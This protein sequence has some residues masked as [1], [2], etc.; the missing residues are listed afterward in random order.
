MCKIKLTTQVEVPAHRSLSLSYTGP[1]AKAPVIDGGGGTRLFGVEAGATL[2]LTGVVLAG[3]AATGIDGADGSDGEPGEDGAPG[4]N[5]ADGAFGTPAPGQPGTKGAFATSG[6]SG[7]PGKNGGS[8]TGGAVFNAGK[9]VLTD[10]AVSNS[11]ATGGGGGTGG[12]GGNG[13]NGGDGGH[14]GQGGGSAAGAPG[15]SGADGGVGG[16]GGDSGNGGKGG[17]AE[18]GAIFNS[19]RLVVNGCTFSGDIATGGSGGNAP[20]G[21]SG[22]PAAGGGGNGGDGGY[23]GPGNGGSN[24]NGGSGGNGAYGGN[25]GSS[26]NGGNGGLA[27]GGA[28]SNETGSVKISDSDFSN[29]GATGG[30]AGSG[31]NGAPGGKGGNGG[32]AGQGSAVGG[33]PGNGGAGGGAG[34]GGDPGASGSSYGGAIYSTNPI[35]LDGKKVPPKAGSPVAHV[36]TTRRTRAHAAADSGTVFHLN[37]TK[38]GAHDANCTFEY[39][40]LQSGTGCYGLGAASAEGGTGGSGGAT[41]IAT[42]G[43]EGSDGLAGEAGKDGSPPPQQGSV[44]ADGAD[45]YVDGDDTLPKATAEPKLAC[46]NNASVTSVHTGSTAHLLTRGSAVV[47][48]GGAT[49]DVKISYRLVVPETGPKSHTQVDVFEVSLAHR[50][51]VPGKPSPV[52]GRLFA[53][54]GVRYDATGD[55]DAMSRVLLLEAA[56]VSSNDSVAHI[57]EASHYGDLLWNPGPP[58]GFN[59]HGEGLRPSGPQLIWNPGG[60]GHGHHVAYDLDYGNPNTGRVTLDAGQVETGVKLID[61]NP[62]VK[63]YNQI[64]ST[65]STFNKL[66]GGTR[67]ERCQVGTNA[68]AEV[69]IS[70]TAVVPPLHDLLQKYFVAQV[71]FAVINHPT[72]GKA[73]PPKKHGPGKHKKKH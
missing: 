33:N 40:L 18:G 3:G 43:K 53:F 30:A 29:D 60:D 26:G 48:A 4:L 17:E 12:K 38:I 1:E 34:S 22:S 36:I 42:N 50:T 52:G 16:N 10:C 56:P 73:T 62:V 45:I 15:G 25:G 19:G 47:A 63:R 41:V 11:T 9:L 8:A 7:G 54:I 13:G 57:A 23:G 71:D 67:N 58:A 2:K 44:V 32:F 37:A 59:I 72:P 24:A 28:I 20:S 69:L 51:T 6:T 14:G 65:L 46:R 68:V 55:L 61:D 35:T 64:N 27:A 21:D 70:P 49:V 66:S 39:D 31:G 5:G